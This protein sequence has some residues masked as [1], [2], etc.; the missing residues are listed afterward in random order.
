MATSTDHPPVWPPGDGGLHRSTST[1]SFARRD[2][3]DGGTSRRWAATT[4]HRRLGRIAVGNIDLHEYRKAKRKGKL[5][6]YT[7]RVEAKE[8]VKKERKNKGN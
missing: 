3:G 8:S 4:G 7:K 2:A 1:T 5:W 6:F